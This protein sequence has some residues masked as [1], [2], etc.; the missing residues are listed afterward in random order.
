[1]APETKIIATLVVIAIIVGAFWL[2][3][4]EKE[5]E[6]SNNDSSPDNMLSEGQVS[7]IGTLVCLPHR[8]MDGPQTLECAFGLRDMNGKYYSLVDTDPSLRN[9][10]G[11]PTNAQI[12]VM[13]NFKW[14]EDQK[15]ISSGVIIIE[16]IV[17]LGNSTSTADTAV[18]I[19]TY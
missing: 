13:G 6:I 8:D 2:F 12:E 9:I 19:Q 4:S 14:Q 10:I 17:I 11:I 3:G 16:S 1:M 7:V 18:P 15:Y 5:M